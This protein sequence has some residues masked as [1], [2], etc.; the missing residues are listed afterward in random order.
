MT[1]SRLGSSVLIHRFIYLEAR[2]IFN[3]M[4]IHA[5]PLSICY[6]VL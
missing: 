5:G 2:Y 6:P 1:G 4:T 3:E